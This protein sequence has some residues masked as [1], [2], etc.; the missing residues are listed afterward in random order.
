[1]DKWTNEY[2]GV[3]RIG[4]VDCDEYPKICTEQGV[5]KFPTFKI[6]PPI[7]MPPTEITDDITIDKIQRMASKHLHS[8]I[9]EITG[10]NI[11]T[12]LA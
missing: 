3:F 11:Q 9:I 8:N 12:Y 10:S 1:M 6:Y 2:N 4:S 5:S 7:P